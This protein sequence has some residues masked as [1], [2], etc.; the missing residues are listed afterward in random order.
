MRYKVISPV[1][2]D[3]RHYRIGESIELPEPEAR[4]LMEAGA[5]ESSPRRFSREVTKVETP[6]VFKTE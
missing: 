4:Q 2:H 1:N 6:T 3:N 5:I